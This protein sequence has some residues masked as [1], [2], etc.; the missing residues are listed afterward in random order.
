MHAAPKTLHS[1]KHLDIV[2]SGNRSFFFVVN[3]MAQWNQAAVSA[4][5][6]VMRVRM[7][8]TASLPAGEFSL[9]KLS[10]SA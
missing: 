4:A 7:V 5:S 9:S 6:P 2:Q 8:L 10:A 3:L 1:C